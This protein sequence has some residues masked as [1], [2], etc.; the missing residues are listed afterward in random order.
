MRACEQKPTKLSF[1][2]KKNVVS[3]VSAP[4]WVSLQSN[5]C[6]IFLQIIGEHRSRDTELKGRE[7]WFKIKMIFFVSLEA[8]SPIDQTNDPRN[9]NIWAPRKLT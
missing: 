9:W 1:L 7:I 8:K 5:E 2:Q 3:D 6:E 4:Y